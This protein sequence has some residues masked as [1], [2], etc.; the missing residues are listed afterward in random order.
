MLQYRII[1]FW[2][3]NI[4]SVTLSFQDTV[5]YINAAWLKTR[6]VFW[7]LQELSRLF[8][9]DKKLKVIPLE[10]RCGPDGG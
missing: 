2:I 6:F 8:Q 7:L 5:Y 1:L 10:A 9:K 4:L 3:L